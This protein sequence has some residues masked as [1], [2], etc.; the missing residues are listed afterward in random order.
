MRLLIATPE[1]IHTGGGIAT[2]Y[3]ELAAGLVS[4]G[5]EVEDIEGSALEIDDGV[6]ETQKGVKVH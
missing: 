6:C 4:L 3:R 1:Y 2:Y 5:V